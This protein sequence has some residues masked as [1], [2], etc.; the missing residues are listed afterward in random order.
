MLVALSWAITLYYSPGTMYVIDFAL[1]LKIIILFIN[2][3]S[4][5]CISLCFGQAR[6]DS[7]SASWRTQHEYRQCTGTS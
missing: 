2:I 3:L 7:Y 6:S 5:K 1:L 4:S